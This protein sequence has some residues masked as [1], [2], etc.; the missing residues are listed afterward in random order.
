M[1][2]NSVWVFVDFI[3]SIGKQK[4]LIPMDLEINGQWQSTLTAM[5]YDVGFCL[6]PLLVTHCNHTLN[7]SFLRVE[8]HV[9]SNQCIFHFALIFL[10][11]K[12][13]VNTYLWW[14]M[15]VILW[16]MM[17]GCRLNSLSKQEAYMQQKFSILRSTQSDDACMTFSFS[18]FFILLAGVIPSWIGF[19]SKCITP[20]I[21]EKI[22]IPYKILDMQDTLIF[23]NHSIYSI[24]IR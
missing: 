22:K 16:M 14:C 4:L 13:K 20:F 18:R 10:F 19:H 12:N 2:S 15:Y 6:L 17:D 8:L 1:Q 9:K 11:L 21:L 23:F 7:N 5:K 24:H 3:T